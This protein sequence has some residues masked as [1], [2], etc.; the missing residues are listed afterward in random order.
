V[1]LDERGVHRLEDGRRLLL[2]G[3]LVAGERQ[4]PLHRRPASAVGLVTVR[5]RVR[6]RVEVRVRG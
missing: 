1:V 6:D 2:P 4:Q 5:V 3:R